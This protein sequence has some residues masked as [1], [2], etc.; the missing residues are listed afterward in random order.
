MVQFFDERDFLA[1]QR[2][3]VGDT[4]ADEAIGVNELHHTELLVHQG[5]VDVRSGGPG[6]LAIAAN[7]SMTG[8]CATS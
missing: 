4:T 1:L 6:D 3:D 7:A 5:S 2:V 8:W